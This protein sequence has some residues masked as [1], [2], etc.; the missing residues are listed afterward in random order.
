MKIENFT[1]V[2]LFALLYYVNFGAYSYNLGGIPGLLIANISILV[3]GIIGL[4]LI[5]RK[6]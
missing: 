4:I 6:Q 1:G 3:G 2:L 5:R